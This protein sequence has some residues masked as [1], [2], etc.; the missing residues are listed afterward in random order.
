MQAGLTRGLRMHAASWEKGL[1]DGRRGLVWWPGAGTEPLS[2][3]AGYTE[4]QSELDKAGGVHPVSS[5]A[6]PNRQGTRDLLQGRG[7]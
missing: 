3:A 1:A 6:R 7:P 2:Y 4:G 5:L